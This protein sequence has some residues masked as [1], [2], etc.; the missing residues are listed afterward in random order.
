MAW[1]LS[2]IL[3]VALQAL[4]VLPGSAQ[5]DAPPPARVALVVAN[6]SYPQAGIPGAAE[7]GR[8]VAAALREGGFDVVLVEDAGRPELRRAIATFAGKLKRGSEAVVFYTGHAL[9]R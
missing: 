9:Q 4:C 1:L 6:G 5:Q 2:L 8:A 7:D 3:A